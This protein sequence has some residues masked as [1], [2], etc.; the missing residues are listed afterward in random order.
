MIIVDKNK[1]ENIKKNIID[2]E[3]LK[4]CL[5][6]SKLMKGVWV[7]VNKIE[8]KRSIL[9]FAE[10]GL[11]KYLSVTRE[12]AKNYIKKSTI[13]KSIDRAPDVVAHYSQEQLVCCIIR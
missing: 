1:L 7:T 2:L 11:I 13:E 12:E 8:L 3:F 4:R 9:K 10:D 6:Y 5:D